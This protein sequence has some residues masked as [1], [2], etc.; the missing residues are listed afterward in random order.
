[1]QDRETEEVLDKVVVEES[2]ECEDPIIPLSAE[3]RMDEHVSP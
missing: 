2:S 3:G 1:M